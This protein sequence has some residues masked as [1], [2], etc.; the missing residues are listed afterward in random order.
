MVETS[1]AIEEA[2]LE[3]PGR[4]DKAALRRDRETIETKPQ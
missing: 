3:A 2:I 1:T 4:A